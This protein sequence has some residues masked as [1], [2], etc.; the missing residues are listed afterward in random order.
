[1]DAERLHETAG[2]LRNVRHIVSYKAHTEQDRQNTIAE[3]GAGPT[4]RA[5]AFGGWANPPVI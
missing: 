4:V 3:T 1:M 2:V 5:G